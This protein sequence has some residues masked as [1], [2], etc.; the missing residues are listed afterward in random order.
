[1]MTMAM[2]GIDEDEDEAVRSTMAPWQRN[3]MLAYFPPDENGMLRAL[4]LS[5]LDPYTYNKQWLVALMNGQYDTAEEK[6]AASM[7]TL[8]APFLGTDIAAGAIGEV[9]FNKK[10][11]GGPVFDENGDKYEQAKQVITHL[12]KTLQAGVFSNVERSLLA[13]NDRMTTYGKKY[14]LGDEMAALVGFRLTTA[15][16][17][18][19]IRFRSYDFNDARN[20]ASRPLNRALRDPNEG[21]WENVA[22]AVDLSRRT[23]E[24]AFKDM[25]K[26]VSAARVQG[27]DDGIIRQELENGGVAKKDIPYLLRGDIPRFS[28]SRQ[29]LR[30]ARKAA[31]TGRS[32]VSQDEFG[33]RIKAMR[34]VLGKG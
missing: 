27:L 10:L 12:R 31:M 24:R 25:I 2:L 9:W 21:A 16:P 13:A 7:G 28:L 4:D 22:D 5:H 19:S 18:L 11:T 32:P 6:L 33:K 26:V 1:M 14:D 23:W 17:A 3:A 15:D 20:G 34:E 8:L 29:S 30:N